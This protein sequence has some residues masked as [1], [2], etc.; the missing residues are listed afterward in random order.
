MRIDSHQHFWLV[1][2]GDYPWLT[3]S[4]TK[5]YRDFLPDDLR[6]QL[7]AHA[8]DRT[9]VVQA[10]P[11][12]SETDFLLDLAAQTDFIAGVVGWLDLESERFKEQFERYRRNA[13][14]ARACCKASARSPRP[15]SRWT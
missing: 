8:I 1:R 3:P 15:I 9:I 13:H 2:R 5:L 12:L 11:T 4:L 7:K 14:C 10:A 6:P